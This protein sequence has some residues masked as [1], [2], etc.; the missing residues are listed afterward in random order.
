MST[1]G[2]LNTAFSGLN[3]ARQGLNVVGQNIANAN[4]AGYTRQRVST[5]SV[6]ATADVGLFSG[7]TRAGQG[8]S[9]DGVAR[10][11]DSFLDARVRSTTAD[12][13]YTAVRSNALTAIEDSTREPGEDGISAKLTAFWAGWGAVSNQ[14]GE[15]APAVLLLSAANALTGQ[16]ASGYS[17]LEDQWSQTRS[18][19]DA[20][21]TD[22]NN[23]ASQVAD[24]NAAIRSTLAAGG[25][26]N[27]LMD[28]RS[29]L[30]TSI[31]SLAGGTV[32]EAKDGT[33]DVYIGGNPLVTGATSRTV[34][35][36]G[37]SSM[38]ANG[39]AAPVQLE[40]ADNPGQMV[41][42]DGG[43]IAGAISVLAPAD[44]TDSGGAIA[45]AAKS[46]NDFA[47][48]LSAA[49]NAVH[50][51]GVTSAGKPGTNFFASSGGPA[52]KNLT[53]VPQ[54]VADLATGAP[55][56][57]GLDGSNADKISQLGTGP[58]SPDSA[59]STFITKLGVSSRTEQQHGTLAAA[60][61]SAA[62]Q[63]QASSASVDLDEENMNMLSY[64]H[65][66]QAAARVMTAVDDML[67]TLINKTGLV[68]R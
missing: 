59:W 52:A 20:M 12:A 54:S 42:L 4:T 68:G 49:V 33:V 34:K 35:L 53:V 46:Y 55:G 1:F 64:Q 57:G 38:D 65:A 15:P 47:S 48:N 14:A 62:V 9:V 7:G 19:T 28:Q 8:V 31:A 67:D 50:A 56:A 2:A 16:L 41:P 40:W 43:E 18:Q 5:S 27:E 58:A 10:L 45:E 22:L 23:A 39:A 29:T 24:L 11:G 21:T 61:A 6:P 3:A 63:T 51:G 25:S 44:G 66:Y 26:A 37:A 30:T 13:G 32:R 60:S 36:T 17:A